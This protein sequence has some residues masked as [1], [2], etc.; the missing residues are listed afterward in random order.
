MSVGLIA[1]C[2]GEG[3]DAD[4]PKVGGTVQTADNGETFNQA[5][6]EFATDLIRHHAMGLLLVDL[7]DPATASPDLVRLS[8]S[9][10]DKLAPQI[11]TLATQLQDWD[12]PVPETVRDHANAHEEDATQD[13]EVGSD[14]PG[15]PSDDQIHELENA[16]GA[17]FEQLWL[18]LM[19]EH[20][21][22]AIDIAEIEV[23]EGRHAASTKLAS[24]VITQ[25]R[26]QIT[27]MRDLLE[28]G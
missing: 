24:T 9:M 10:R 5:D 26:N 16:S 27:R 15:M 7:V 13:A 19:A 1:A 17:E 4:E 11:Q 22:G 20:H 3:D 18:Q 2:G 28:T 8:G 12:Q 23:D 21:D 14:L 6:V 25:Q